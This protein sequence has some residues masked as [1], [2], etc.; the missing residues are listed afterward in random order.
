MFLASLREMSLEFQCPSGSLPH[1][2]PLCLL[3]VQSRKEWQELQ[4]RPATQGQE[5]SNQ[6]LRSLGL[7]MPNPAP[8]KSS[9]SIHK[10]LSLL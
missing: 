6:R 5:E 9:D 3:T 2:S 8:L 4:D 1:P 7:Q 10:I